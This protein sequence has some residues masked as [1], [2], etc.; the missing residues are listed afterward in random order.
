MRQ[1]AMMP[2]KCFFLH[3]LCLF[4]PSLPEE[5]HVRKKSGDGRVVIHGE[6]CHFMLLLMSKGDSRPSEKIDR[7]Q[8][9]TSQL[10]P[11][12]QGRVDHNQIKRG[13][14]QSSQE[15]TVLW[16]GSATL[17]VLLVLADSAES[18]WP[19]F[20]H[21]KGLQQP[22]VCKAPLF[23]TQQPSVLRTP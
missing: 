18:S 22:L 5:V 2:R 14:D 8:R 11:K 10:L 20:K 13:S 23:I 12:W 4:L 1:E 16:K 19:Y 9:R 17:E 15:K 7:H 6:F 3:S 21:D